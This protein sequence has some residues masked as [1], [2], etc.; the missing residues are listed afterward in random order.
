MEQD[1]IIQKGDTAKFQVTITHA[2]FDQ[3]TD[4]FYVVVRYGIPDNELRVDK[5][6]MI[7]DEDGNFFM[8]LP[9][10][11]LAGRLKAECHYSVS[12]GDT[13]GTREEVDIQWLAFVTDSPCPRFA[14]NPC[15]GDDTHVQY[16]RIWRSDT[17]SLYLNLRTSDKMPV[18]DSD[19][20][21]IRVRKEEK[22]LI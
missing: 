2:D 18:L 4:D 10:S 5:K 20:N 9:T 16:K 14:C 21:Q 13:G 17:S 8:L 15:W 12:D 22:D 19:G 3:Q 11:E 7:H 1:R 6:D